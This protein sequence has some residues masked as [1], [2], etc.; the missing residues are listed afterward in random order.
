MQ[1]VAVKGRILAG[2]SLRAQQLIIS[3]PQPLPAS[4]PDS[5]RRFSAAT[6]ALQVTE[7]LPGPWRPARLSNGTHN[8]QLPQS[9]ISYTCHMLDE[10]K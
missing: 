9:C 7:S 6:G 10:H 5:L 8:A 1:V 3:V 4:S 2:D